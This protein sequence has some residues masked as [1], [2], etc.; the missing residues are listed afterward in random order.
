MK[1]G[2]VLQSKFFWGDVGRWFN[3]LT[4]HYRHFRLEH[5]CIID[6]TYHC[7]ICCAGTQLFYQAG[8]TIICPAV[9]EMLE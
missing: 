6:C 8:D 5:A 7:R 2:N 3:H 4:Y 9:K 1:S